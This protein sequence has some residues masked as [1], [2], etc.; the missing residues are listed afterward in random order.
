M[1]GKIEYAERDRSW[2][3]MYHS[4]LSALSGGWHPDAWANLAVALDGLGDP[5]ELQKHLTTYA[6]NVE[7]P[8][9]PAETRSFHFYM[10]GRLYQSIGEYD[11]A[12]AAFMRAAALAGRAESRALPMLQT[13]MINTFLGA[14]AEAKANL[15][16]ALTDAV[17]KHDM[18]SAA[19]AADFLAGLC[20]KDDLAEARRYLSRATQYAQEAGNQHR[21][22]WLLFTEGEIEVRDENIDSGINLMFTAL[23]AFETAENRG[24][25]H[26]CCARLAGHLMKR[27]RYDDVRDVLKRGMELGAAFRFNRSRARILRLCAELPDVDPRE[28][29]HLLSQAKLLERRA[30]KSWSLL[31]RRG[32][33]F[34]DVEASQFVK[35]LSDELF[36]WLCCRILTEEGYKC[37]LTSRNAPDIDI[38]ASKDIGGP[39]PMKWA[40]S[41]KRWNANA[42]G[43]DNIPNSDVIERLDC[44][45]FIIMTSGK[46]SVHATERLDYLRT[47]R[48]W[49]EVWDGH[50]IAEFVATH[51]EIIAELGSQL[52]VSAL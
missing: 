22:D 48:I 19:H 18:M 28:R 44:M 43:K 8:D 26:H 37:D 51:D 13:G 31:E 35:T 29:P 7:N 34:S 39:E 2:R 23:N 4:S 25:A 45:G 38:I 42:V 16:V 14:N 20:S 1:Y 30:R 32:R 41:C 12:L 36:E 47:K 15:E 5:E 17:D 9:T 3:R 6:P 11:L 33:I 52:T 24:S 10:I 40:V 21:L 50:N 27:K 46:I 49:R